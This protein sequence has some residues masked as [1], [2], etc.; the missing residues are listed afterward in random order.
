MADDDRVRRKRAHLLATEAMIPTSR[1]GRLWRTGHAAASLLTST[2][3]ARFRGG[4][5]VMSD[6]DLHAIGRLVSRLGELKGVAMKAGQILG[7]IDPSLAP[8]LRGMLSLLQ[9]AAAPTPF[10]EVEAT[11]RAAF[12]ERAHA[13]VSGL[14]KTPV[15]VASIGQVHR[16]HVGGADLAVKVRHPGIESALR[17][18]FSAAAI[19]P[20]F[21]G[22]V[23]PGAGESVESFVAEARAALLE[24]CDFALEA[25]RQAQFAA[26][27]AGHPTIHVPEVVTEWCAGSVLTTA[28]AAGMSLDELLA[29]DPPQATRDRLGIALFELYL[30]TLYRRGVFH[31]DPHPGNYAFTSDAEVIVYDFGC[32]R[33]FDHATVAALSSLVAAVRVDD[34]GAIAE[35]LRALGA[36]PPSA[37]QERAHVR[38]L[39]RAFFAPLLVSGAHRIHPGAAL[40]AR[41]ALRDKR[42]L[43]RLCLPGKLLFLFRI[44]F[45]LYAVLSRLGSVVDWS[46]LESA[47]A[48]AALRAPRPP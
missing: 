19:G 25:S 1:F 32:V 21:A 33:S 17:A 7:Y 42:A 47:W 34:P 29:T 30:G 10:E 36:T 20:A 9:T 15:A 11:L 38:Q 39:L 13:L 3:G 8:E 44:R 24:E 40:E 43:M 35:A 41:E 6:A 18:D 48:A 27:F 16:A 46:G 31:A 37:R 45:G 26:W 22:L 2:L 14:D 12:G 28:W 4:D 23:V 5:D